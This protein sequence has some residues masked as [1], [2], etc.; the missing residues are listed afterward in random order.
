TGVEG[1][2]HL[3]FEVVDNSVDEALM[4]YCTKI[5]VRIHPDGSISVSD[6]GRGIPVEVHRQSGRSAVEVVLTKLHAGGKFGSY[7]YKISGGLH[8]VGVSVVNALSEWLEVNVHQGGRIWT[9][10]FERGKPAGDLL[11]SGRTEQTGTTIRFKPDPEVFTDTEFHFEIVSKRVKELAFLNEGLTM[12]LVDERTGKEKRY[13]FQGGI[14]ALVTY[15][16]RGKVV[17]HS[18]PISFSAERNE[19]RA[20]VA[21]QYNDGYLENVI[22]FANNINTLE[23]GTHLTGL[24]TALTRVIGEYILRHEL[25]KEKDEP[26]TGNDIREG[27]V[28]VVSVLMPDPQFEGQTKTKLGNPEIRG[29][30]EDLT[31]ESL[32]TYLEENP[33]TAKVITEKIIQASRARLAAKRARE[34]ARK[35][36]SL[37]SLIL[38]GKLSDCA[39]RNPETTELFIVEG[40]SAGG[41]AK[42]GRDRRYQAI[43]PLRGK[44]LNVEKANLHRILSSEEIR[45]LVAALGCGIGQDLTPEKLRYHKIIIMTDADVDGAHIRTLLLTLFY[46]YMKNLIEQGSVFIARPPLYRVREG[47]NDYYAYSDKDLEV[48]VKGL[49][50]KKYG[51]QRYKGLGEMNPEQLWET[52]MNPETR[53]LKRVLIEDTIEAEE[54]FSILMGDAVEPRREFIQEHALEV[55]DLDI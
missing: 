15:L 40:D 44:I 51:I 16:N 49:K 38:P 41:S 28:A 21:L 3:I 6:D 30:I 25:I 18:N 27:L 36:N 23:G 35:K 29:M 33:E 46:R 4:G 42:Q 2:H 9:Q 1:L 52:A 34:L 13:C 8:G 50:N 24:K 45:S 10:R 48:V 43:L 17:L 11:D 12:C 7:A 14:R 32:G 26:P 53:T 19:A 37:D 54:V 47:K 20:E 22:S 39:E 5:E 31:E 55:A